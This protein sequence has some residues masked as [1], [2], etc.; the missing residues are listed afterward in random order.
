MPKRRRRSKAAMG[1]WEKRRKE[2][3]SPPTNRPSTLKKWKD[4]NM[5]AAMQAVRS[6]QCGANKAARLHNVPPTTLK[7]RLSGRVKHGDKPGPDPYLTEA[8]EEELSTFLMNCSKI[9]Y[10]KTR[11]EVF[12]I[13]QRTIKKKGRSVENFNGEG[14]WTRFMARHPELSLRCSDPLSRVRS[15]AVTTENMNYFAL[16]K[17]TL[18][19]KDLLDKPSHIIYNMD[20]SGMPLDPKPLKRVACKGMKKVHGQASGDKS[21]ITVVG[22]ANAAGR[23][24]PPMVIFK[25]ERFNHEWSKG[26]VPDTLYGMSESGWIDSELFYY[27]LEKLFLLHNVL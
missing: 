27:W 8:E 11:R 13:V 5:L 2:D 10:G 23:S 16:L 12:G 26:E 17:K 24:L 14:W 15:N 4:D 20:E 21:Q 22:C 1:G 3:T 7:D 25:G 6:G 9:G 18:V 19:E